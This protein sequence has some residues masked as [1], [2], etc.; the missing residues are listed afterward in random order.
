M[1]LRRILLHYNELHFVTIVKYHIALSLCRA[2]SFIVV[3]FI[4]LIFIVSHIVVKKI[5]CIALHCIVIYCFVLYNILFQ[6]VLG[7]ALSCNKL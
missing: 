7:I 3:V 2:E 1:A 4:A 6:R 5:Y